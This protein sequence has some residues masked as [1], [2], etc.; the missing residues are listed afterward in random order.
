MVQSP[1]WEANW[2][3]ASQEIPCIL[4]KPKVHYRILSGEKKTSKLCIFF[5][6][7]LK[8]TIRNNAASKRNILVW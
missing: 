4:R 3:A 6:E 2:F 1:S 7:W 5:K 8:K